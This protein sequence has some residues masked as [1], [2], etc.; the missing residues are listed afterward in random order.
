MS[1]QAHESAEQRRSGTIQVIARAAEILRTLERHP[2]GL[3]LSQIAR[4]VG[5][6]RS[7]VQRIIATLEE[8]RF[9]VPSGPGGGFRLG[10]GLTHLAARVESDLRREVRPFLDALS[11]ELD[12]TVDLSIL[13]ADRALFIDQV[14]AP[15]RLRA[16]SAVGASFPLHC[17][18]NGKAFLAELPVEQVRQLL[19]KR[20]EA[21]TRYTITDHKA[22]LDELI[23]LRTTGVGFDREEHTEGICA[24]AAVIRDAAG[25]VASISV[26]LPATRFYGNEDKVVTALLRTCAQI[27]ARLGAPGRPT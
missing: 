10:P 11:R 17:C 18:A 13:D 27:N 22:L 23:Q 5:L 8:E 12:E 21:R 6:P 25:N 15:Q 24:V 3:T 14:A 19:P 2:G 9:V 16:V 26:P 4:E 1:V 7:T 20:L